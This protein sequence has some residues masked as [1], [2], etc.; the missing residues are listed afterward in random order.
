MSKK[1]NIETSIY[2]ATQEFKIVGEVEYEKFGAGRCCEGHP[3]KY[4]VELS[5]E[6]GNIYVFGSTCVYKPFVL[7][8]WELDSNQLEDPNVMRAG[9]NLWIIARDNLKDYITEI[10]H[11]KDLDWDFVKLNEKLKVIVANAKKTKKTHLKKLAMETKTKLRIERFRKTNETQCELIRALVKKVKYLKE[12]GE[13]GLLSSWEREFIVSI[14]GQHRDMRVLSEKQRAIMERI[15]NTEISIE[16]HSAENKEI[17]EKLTKAVKSLGNLSIKEH[18]LILSFQ[19]QFFRK[20]SL[21]ERQLE[22]LDNIIHSDSNK[23]I[24]IKMKSWITEQKSG[25]E[26]KYGVIKSVEVE[27]ARAILCKFDV[28]G[29]EFK[30][31]VPKS[32]LYMDSGK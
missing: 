8:H 26:G 25:L 17:A 16:K 15:I 18:E 7:K 24:G 9:R 3:I 32:Q 14:I 28:D 1:I 23:Y 5:D 11:P 22:V 10:P 6:E 4:G 29:T 2:L 21:S 30:S 12:K 27:T 13:L 19:N 20:G 31:W